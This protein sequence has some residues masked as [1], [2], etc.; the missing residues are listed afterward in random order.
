[1]NGKG[2]VER[3]GVKFGD[4]KMSDRIIIDALVCYGPLT[5]TDLE[6]KT[7]LSPAT[8]SSRL[9]ILEAKGILARM[10]PSRRNCKI[11][12]AP[13]YDRPEWAAAWKLWGSRLLPGP[14]PFRGFEILERGQTTETLKI[15]SSL[16][17]G[18]GKCPFHPANFSC[19]HEFEQVEKIFFPL[20]SV[21]RPELPRLDETRLL[22]ALAAFNLELDIQN[23]LDPTHP[24]SVLLEALAPH[25]GF[26]G[27]KLRE[28][29]TEHKDDWEVFPAIGIAKRLGS[30]Q[31][32]RELL[33]LVAPFIG[34]QEKPGDYIRPYEPPSPMIYAFVSFEEAHRKLLTDAWKQKLGGGG[35]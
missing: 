26:D 4:L 13:P 20:H 27:K 16:E 8:L 1:M 2:E 32:L 33:D 21:I 11:V 9:S 18:R 35:S 23:W 3:K 25:W 14:D 7:E 28:F 5:F 19:Y 29:L 24:R 30:I 12:F 22:L 34:V 15:L 31:N 10:G 17:L 6:Q